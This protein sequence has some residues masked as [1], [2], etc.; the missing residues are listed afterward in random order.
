MDNPVSAVVRIE[1]SG[2]SSEEPPLRNAVDLSALWRRLMGRGLF[3]TRTLW[4]LFLDE[5]DRPTKLI[6]PIEDI[7]AEPDL[8]A[9]DGIGRML[10]GVVNGALD[11]VLDDGV[12]HH[13][14]GGTV[15]MLLSRPGSGVMTDGDRRWAAEVKRC[16]GRHLGPWPVH[17]A[18]WN[19]IRVFAPDDLIAAL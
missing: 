5:T 11:G 17:L 4:L 8:E 3:E 7:P 2:M 16:L 13:G 10:D 12:L 9:L 6:V 15:P 19:R 18:T 1:T 14:C